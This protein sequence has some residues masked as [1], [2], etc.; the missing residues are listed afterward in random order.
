MLEQMRKQTQST[1]M[2]ILFGF[3]I[4]VFVFSFGA[5]SVGFRKGGC[6]RSGLVA[7]VNGEDVGEMEFQYYY[8]QALRARLRGRQ[9]PLTREEKI[10]LRQQVLNAIIDRILL[11]QAAHRAGLRVTD[12]ERNRSIR[13]AFKDKDGRFDLKRYKFYLT[14]YLQTTPA[15][16]EENWRERMLADRMAEV[17]KDTA[18]V[19]EDELRQAFVSRETKVQLSFVKLSVADFRPAQP[20]GDEQVAEFLAQHEQEVRKY[21]DDNSDRYHKPRQV[22]LAHVFFEVRPEYDSEQVQE[23]KEQAEISLDNLKKKASFEEEAKEYS[24]DD[25]TKDK[26]GKLPLSTREAL[27]ARWG[28]KFAQAVFDL[29][30]GQLSGVVRS[31]KGFHVVKCLK[32]ISAE[33]HSFDEVKKDI[34]RQLLLDR[35]ARQAARRE[36][37]RLLAGLHSGKSL[38]ELLG[39]EP[40]KKTKQDQDER[41]AGQPLVRDTGLFARLGAYIPGLGMDQ[42]VARAAFSLSMDKPVPDKVFPIGGSGPNAAFVVFKLVKRQDPDMKQYPQA[43]ERIRKMLL[44]RRRP[45]QLAAWLKQARHQADIQANQAFLADIT[46]PG[47][48]GRS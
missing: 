44:S 9:K 12:S 32:V 25:A 24:E 17:I 21:Y 23:K 3:I 27:V 28:E 29:E 38:E 31:D 15:I 11:V 5:G 18:R 43:K 26:G 36:A 8:D 22:Q 35:Q 47:M 48:R 2:V 45:A 46:P 30:E 7:M 34:A 4:F 40:D 19:N 6:G 42:D 16:F 39:N 13:E 41:K 1:V 37:E 33:D 14:R 10:M 20:P